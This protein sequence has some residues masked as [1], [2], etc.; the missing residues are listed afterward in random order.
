MWHYAKTWKIYH[1]L[2]YVFDFLPISIAPW[3]SHFDHVKTRKLPP[4]PSVEKE[5]M[6]EAWCLLKNEEEGGLLPFP[7]FPLIIK[8]QPTQFSGLHPPAC[9]PVNLRSILF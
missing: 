6:M 3:Q 4:A 1:F 2:G 7:S 8:P 5:L 9:L